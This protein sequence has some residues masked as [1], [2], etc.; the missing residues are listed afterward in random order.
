MKPIELTG[1]CPYYIGYAGAIRTFNDYKSEDCVVAY[2]SCFLGTLMVIR[3][4]RGY[5]GFLFKNKESNLNNN[6]SINRISLDKT[7]KMLSIKDK[8]ELI[9]ISQDLYNKFERTVIFDSLNN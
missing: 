5:Y 4:T 2:K 9:I 8:N 3:G 7:L 6:D 1:N